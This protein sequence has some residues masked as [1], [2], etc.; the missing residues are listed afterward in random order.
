MKL[1]QLTMDNLIQFTALIA[2]IGEISKIHNVNW[3]ILPHFVMLSVG[4][5]LGFEQIIMYTKFH[6]NYYFMNQML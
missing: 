1:L 5:Y 3:Q 2:Y 4:L 6:Q